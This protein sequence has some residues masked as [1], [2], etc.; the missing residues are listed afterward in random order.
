M[1]KSHRSGSRMVTRAVGV[2]AGF[3]F[4]A[5]SAQ[6]QTLV[7]DASIQHGGLT[8][9]FHYY[10]PAGLPAGPVPLVF[11]LHGGTRDN[12][13]MLSGPWGEMLD[14]ADAEKFIV[15]M[16][17]GVDPDDGSTAPDGSFNWN[18]CRG[19]APAVETGADDVGF[20]SAL[21]DWA[22]TQFDVDPERVYA[23]GP[24]NGGLMSYRLAFELSDRI[25]AIGAVIANLP[26][27][28]ECSGPVE[29][30]A[31]LVMN[32]TQD[33]LMPWD[34]G[35]VGNAAACNRGEVLSA[36]ATVD[37]WNLF[38]A[39]DPSPT[40]TDVP[41]NPGTRD[42]TSVSVDVF[43]DG[44]EASEVA[45]FTVQGGGHQTPS[46]EHR[47]LPLL[48]L[49]QQ[50]RDIEAA[51]ELYGFFRNHRLSGGV[52]ATTDAGSSCP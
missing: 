27:N 14:V 45:L 47:T 8:R 19:D 22:D 42:R 37:F 5:F 6:A 4:S 26:A 28:S 15:V 13:D 21:I 23:T 29:A 38:L 43:H 9:Y 41:D 39:T 32:G 50:N 3:W 48:G 20:L 44:L 46:C 36:Q 25:A 52:A 17:N 35:C 31:V 11:T 16:P 12:D 30:V 34:G 40:H 33:D 24:S 49:G 51:R 18:D 7:E 10:V 1:D 2:T